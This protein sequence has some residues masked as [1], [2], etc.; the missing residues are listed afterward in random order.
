[1]E[2]EILGIFYNEVIP[3]ASYGKVEAFL[4][5]NVGFDTFIDYKRITTNNISEPNTIVPTLTIKDKNKFD[6]MLLKYLSKAANFYEARFYDKVY[7]CDMIEFKTEYIKSLMTLL[8]SNATGEDFSNP[9][10]FLRKRTNFFDEDILDENINY[11]ET[12]LGKVSYKKCKDQMFNETP[13]CLEFSIDD[14]PLP[15]VRYGISDGK[16]YIYSIQNITKIT[17]DKKLNRVMYKVNE[18]LD[19][20]NESTDNI[21]NPENL[22][23]IT[24][25]SLIS[26]TLAVSLFKKNGINKIEIVP[27]LPV[28]WNA[29]EIAY[30]RSSKYK[31]NR[32]EY[33][34]EQYN[35]HIEIQRNLSDKFL[36]TFRRIEYH[37]EGIEITSYPF[38]NSENMTMEIGDNLK[39]NNPL[40]SELYNSLNNRHEL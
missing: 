12:S 19:I 37:F 33:L 7:T 11:F 20:A 9:C 31:D 6:S 28:R 8:W 5:F 3:E 34:K 23:G 17:R 40:L 15:V 32:K 16:A 22:V 21:N 14:N 39:S 13:Y 1:M 26:A 18:G 4:T 2:K 35:K 38:V 36:R 10:E 25:S 24:P 29:K 30:F 27:Y